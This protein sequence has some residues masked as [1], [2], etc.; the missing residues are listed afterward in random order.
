MDAYW[1]FSKHWDWLMSRL[2]K[3]VVVGL[4]TGI[5]GLGISLTPFGLNLEEGHGAGSLVQAERTKNG[6]GV[7]S[8]ERSHEAGQRHSLW[9]NLA[10]KFFLGCPA[11]FVGAAETCEQWVAKVVSVQGVVQIRRAGET[12]WLPVNFNDTY[13]PAI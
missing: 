11:T 1:L 5:S 4:F 3:A 6:C 9:A 2:Y 7:R 12:E 13:C 10:G 8:K